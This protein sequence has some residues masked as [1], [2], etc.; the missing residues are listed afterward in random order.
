MKATALIF[1]PDKTTFAFFGV[2]ERVYL[3]F[4]LQSINCESNG[5]R[6]KTTSHVT[7]ELFWQ[8]F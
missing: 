7:L 4:Q 3:N 5:H 6:G 2:V 8:Q 1:F